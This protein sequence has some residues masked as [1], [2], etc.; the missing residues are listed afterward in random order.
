MVQLYGRPGMY[1]TCPHTSKSWLRHLLTSSS[2]SSSEITRLFLRWPQSW[3]NWDT[4]Y[5]RTGSTFSENMLPTSFSFAPD[6]ENKATQK[7]AKLAQRSVGTTG[8]LAAGTPM[9]IV[10][11]RACPY[12]ACT[13]FTPTLIALSCSA[14]TCITVYLRAGLL[15]PNGIVNGKVQAHYYIRYGVCAVG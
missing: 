7:A 11:S 10:V 9:I 8:A 14:R 13:F 2:L 1:N 6:W 12:T 5:C 4:Q 15:S 3:C